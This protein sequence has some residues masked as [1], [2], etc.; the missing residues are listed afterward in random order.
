M[1]KRKVILQHFGD[2]IL[3]WL[4]GVL[5]TLTLGLAWP[6]I[7]PA[8][9]R[10]EHYYGAGPGMPLIIAI[11][12]AVA[13]PAAIM[14]GLVGGA[15]SVEGGARGRRMITILVAILL[16]LPCAGWGYWFFTGY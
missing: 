1:S 8:V 13:S 7:F 14:G 16:S 11:V 4:A 12:L 9:V 15:L 2:A 3:G 6:I 10:V 5:A